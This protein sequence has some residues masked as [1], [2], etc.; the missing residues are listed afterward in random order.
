MGKWFFW[1]FSDV[2]NSFIVVDCAIG[3]IILVFSFVVLLVMTQLPVDHL[4][5]MTSGIGSA[6]LVF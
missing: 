2:L 4:M 6:N 5:D 1:G 3:D